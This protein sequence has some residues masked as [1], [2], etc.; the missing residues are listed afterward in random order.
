MTA[1]SNNLVSY[2][3]LQIQYLNLCRNIFMVMHLM[4]QVYVLYRY[5]T[6][7][8]PILENIKWKKNPV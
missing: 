8:V 6:K 7:N 4:Q 2:L 1:I 5:V 3:W